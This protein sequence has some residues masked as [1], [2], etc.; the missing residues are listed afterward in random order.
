MTK[1]EFKNLVTELQEMGNR[2]GC[3]EEYVH[4]S[5]RKMWELLVEEQEIVSFDEDSIVFI[6]IAVAYGALKGSKD[7]LVDM[8]DVLS[9]LCTYFDKEEL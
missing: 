9:K 3:I 5:I 8:S 4:N 7:A 2:I 6:E 1:K